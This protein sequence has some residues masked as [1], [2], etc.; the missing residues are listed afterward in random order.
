MLKP[1][2]ERVTKIPTKDRVPERIKDVIRDRL[3]L[4]VFETGEL[5]AMHADVLKRAIRGLRKQD[6]PIIVDGGLAS[7]GGLACFRTEVPLV[8][9]EAWNQVP[10][11]TVSYIA[12]VGGTNTKFERVTKISSTEM[13]LDSL[14]DH[15]RVYK[16]IQDP[17]K[18]LTFG[19]FIERIVDPVATTYKEDGKKGKLHFGISL[20]FSHDNFPTKDGVDAEFVPTREDGTLTKG[21]KITD[22]AELMQLPADETEKRRFIPLIKERL[23]SVHGIEPADVDVVIINDTPGTALDRSAAK[24]AT[25]QGLKVLRMGAVGGT[26]TN[27]AG[28]QEGLINFEV[29]RVPLPLDEHGKADPVTE[30]MLKNLRNESDDPE[31]IAK[32]PELEHITG[33]GF[34]PERLRAAIELLGEEGFLEDAEALADKVKNDKENGALMSDLANGK[35]NYVNPTIEYLSQ[36]ILQQ[37]ATMFGAANAGVIESL[38]GPRY[39]EPNAAFLV[40]GS[41][42]NRGYGVKELVE[43]TAK[44]LGQPIT[45]IEA[46]SKKGVAILSMTWEQMM[47]QAN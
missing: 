35:G 15:D 4:R 43:S 16:G 22:W 3:Q 31:S 40:E 29:G 47:K 20:G 38:Y 28:D 8:T 34:A 36:L 30:R 27:V 11:D 21:W 41:Y 18:K 39:D 42:I 26:G 12:S 44:S 46:D 9:N 45:I 23:A 25:D 19:E 1:D 32:V 17:A 6:R 33:G 24:Q 10:N 7:D 5:E 13:K 2:I 14:R 37:S